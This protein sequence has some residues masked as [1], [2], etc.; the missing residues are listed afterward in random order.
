M[1]ATALPTNGEQPTE[2]TTPV[3]EKQLTNEE[4]NNEVKVESNQKVETVAPTVN[5]ATV[6]AP[7]GLSIIDG[8]T[9][10]VSV[11]KSLDGSRP[12]DGVSGNSDSI[13]LGNVGRYDMFYAYLKIDY[14]NNSGVDLT[15]TSITMQMPK[16]GEDGYY[17]VFQQGAS[18][19]PNWINYPNTPTGDGNTN[20]PASNM[21]TNTTSRLMTWTGTTITVGS[22]GTIYIKIPMRDP[23]TRFGTVDYNPVL[24]YIMNGTVSTIDETAQFNIVGQNDQPSFSLE[25]VDNL[26]FVPSEPDADQYFYIKYKITSNYSLNY[27]LPKR[28]FEFDRVFYGETN[29]GPNIQ[30]PVPAGAQVVTIPTNSTVANNTISSRAH[31]VNGSFI[32]LRYLKTD[33]PDPNQDVSFGGVLNGRFIGDTLPTEDV[34]GTDFT[35][36]HP[37][38]TGSVIPAATLGTISTG[39]RNLPISEDALKVGSVPFTYADMALSRTLDTIAGDELTFEFNGLEYIKDGSSLPTDYGINIIYLYGARWTGNLDPNNPMSGSITVYFDDGSSEVIKTLTEAQLIAANG[40][41]S[42]SGNVPGIAGGYEPPAGKVAKKVVYS[43]SNVPQGFIVQSFVNGYLKGY[44]A[45][46]AEFCSF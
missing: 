4:Q 16:Q 15:N 6:V 29:Q 25:K 27:T 45:G 37:I 14:A 26:G 1:L 28:G 31:Y 24:H 38:G 41:A 30:L 12:A 33:Y 13:D 42:Y 11:A 3:E 40:S 5:E 10:N 46:G 32:V 21:S 17:E 22:T 2:Q 35:L 7:S 43:F 44:P 18:V 36:T 23:F 19:P 9:Y 39:T 20:F 8:I 34:A